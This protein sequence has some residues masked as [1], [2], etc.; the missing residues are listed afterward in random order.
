LF[1]SDANDNAACVGDREIEE[2]G[3]SEMDGPVY[4]AREIGPQQYGVIAGGFGSAEKVQVSVG[5]TDDLEP[6]SGACRGGDVE[7]RLDFKTR[8]GLRLCQSAHRQRQ[9]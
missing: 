9:S 3:G 4:V 7:L 6:E 1:G 5:R 2:F 8:G